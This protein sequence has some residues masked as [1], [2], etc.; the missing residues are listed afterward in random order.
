MK[1]IYLFDPNPFFANQI[2]KSLNQLLKPL[3][4]IILLKSNKDFNSSFDLLILHESYRNCL[5]F[6]IDELDRQRILW[7]TETLELGSNKGE[8]VSR[9]TQVHDW[10]HILLMKLESLKNLEQENKKMHLLFTFKQESRSL[11]F[12]K[13]LLEHK[14]KGKKIF[15]LPF[16]PSY[17]WNYRAVFHSGPDLSNLVLQIEQEIPLTHKDLG[18]IFEKQKDGYF[19]PRPGKSADDIY[20]YQ[21]MTTQKIAKL[22]RDF[23]CQHT[24]DSVGLI[25]IEARPFALVKDIACLVDICHMDLLKD[26][27]YGTEKAKQEIANFLVEKPKN[28]VFKAINFQDLEEL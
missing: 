4:S 8:I 23:I 12:H 19:L 25:D 28:I 21:I 10:Y 9:Q 24:E 2:Q 3:A 27:N 1:T 17:F 22:F 20:D 15:I 26:D 5:N 18:Y 14:S 6:K 7:L 13:W 11:F 16:R